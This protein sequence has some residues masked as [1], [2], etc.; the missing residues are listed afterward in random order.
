[1]QYV[2]KIV[3]FDS[4]ANPAKHDT[5]LLEKARQIGLALAGSSAD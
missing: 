1:M 3:H 2:G 5:E 4:A